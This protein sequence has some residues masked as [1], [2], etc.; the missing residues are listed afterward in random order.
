MP[1]SLYL[2]LAGELSVIV[3]NVGKNGIIDNVGNIGIVGIASSPN[4]LE[5]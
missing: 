1:T 3:D 5:T 4:G 2:T